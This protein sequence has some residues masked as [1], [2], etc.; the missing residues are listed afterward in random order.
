MQS[1]LINYVSLMHLRILS[2]I[3][4]SLLTAKLGLRPSLFHYQRWA[5][6]L[7]RWKALKASNLSCVEQIKAKRINSLACSDFGLTGN[8]KNHTA[9]LEIGFI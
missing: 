3:R 4:K 6:F 8:G 2:S 1:Y 7:V 5:Y 9:Q